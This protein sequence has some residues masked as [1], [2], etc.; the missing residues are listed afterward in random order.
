LQGREGMLKDFERYPRYKELYIKAFD[1]MIK[2]HPGEIK[3][4][5]GEL[6]TD[7]SSGGGEKFSENGFD[8]TPESSSSKPGDQPMDQDE[9][10]RGSVYGVDQPILSSVGGERI[11]LSEWTGEQIFHLWL[12]AHRADRTEQPPCK[13]VPNGRRTA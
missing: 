13:L 4:A 7:D 3:V 1:K 9:N 5:T 8:G 2:N 6:V 10:R 11:M 12:W